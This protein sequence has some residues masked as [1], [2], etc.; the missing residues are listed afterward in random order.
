M[1]TNKKL[2]FLKMK[3]LIIYLSWT[4][5]IKWTML[6]F[7]NKWTS[8]TN[9]GSKTNIFLS[10]TSFSANKSMISSPK[11]YTT[12]SM[13][14]PPIKTKSES[15]ALLMKKSNKSAPKSHKSSTKLPSS[16][17]TSEM[18]KPSD[19]KAL[20]IS[21]KNSSKIKWSSLDLEILATKVTIWEEKEHSLN[22][23]ASLKISET[24]NSGISECLIIQTQEA[25]K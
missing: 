24:S 12:E 22:F 11:N 6:T 8:N 15:T 18:I 4:K 25:T 1:K 20:K 9:T 14:I 5:R 7:K 23:L 16:N 19:L 10:F 3:T 17:L 21:I 2:P 13:S